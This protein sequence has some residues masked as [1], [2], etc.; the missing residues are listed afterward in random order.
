MAVDVNRLL[1]KLFEEFRVEQISGALVR[2]ELNVENFQPAAKQW[3]QTIPTYMN[4]K[5]KTMWCIQLLEKDTQSHF[6]GG[7]VCLNST[8]WLHIS[9]K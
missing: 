2:V 3:S 1:L 5:M 8:L 4:K 9:L 7:G 6:G